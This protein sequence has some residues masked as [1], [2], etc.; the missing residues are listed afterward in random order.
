MW[1][2]LKEN[3][4]GRQNACNAKVI[5]DSLGLPGDGNCREVRRRIRALSLAGAPIVGSPAR[6]DAGFHVAETGE[7]LDACGFRLTR[8]AR[9]IHRRALAHRDAAKLYQLPLDDPRADE[10]PGQD[11]ETASRN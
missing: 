10:E 8:Q 2:W 5:S 1:E 3:A 11:D 4:N 9:Q 7:E 6:N